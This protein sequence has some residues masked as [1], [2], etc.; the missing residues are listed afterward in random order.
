[1]HRAEYY[2][3]LK[4]AEEYQQK[5]ASEPDLQVRRALETVAREYLRR[6]DQ[7]EIEPVMGSEADQRSDSWIS[8]A[9]R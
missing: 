3:Y 2:A 8:G 6:A 1:M 5:A 9:P 7:V 4:K